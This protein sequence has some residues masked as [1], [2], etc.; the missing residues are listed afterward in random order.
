VKFI[1]AQGSESAGVRLCAVCFHAGNYQASFMML[2]NGLVD[3]DGSDD[4]LLERQLQEARK[5]AAD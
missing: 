1:V 3:I 5:Q 2:L 4:R